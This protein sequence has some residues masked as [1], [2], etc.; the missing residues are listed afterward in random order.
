[1]DTNSKWTSNCHCCGR[2]EQGCQHH[3]FTREQQLTRDSK[4]YSTRMRRQF[5]HHEVA[6]N[7]SIFG[8]VAC[9]SFVPVGSVHLSSHILS[10]N[11]PILTNL[12]SQFDV[13]RCCNGAIGGPWSFSSFHPFSIW[14]FLNLVPQ[15]KVCKL[16]RGKR[17]AR[18]YQ[19]FMQTSV[20]TVFAQLSSHF[21]MMLES[22]G[23]T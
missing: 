21:M 19:L 12:L 15:G 10:I 5:H 22:A 3:T 9:I 8:N 1:M 17:W 23:Q 4:D 7:W 6:I 18:L 16:R 14:A 13:T 2:N 11:P 20:A